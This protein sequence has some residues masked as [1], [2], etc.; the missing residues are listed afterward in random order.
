[1]L[2]LRHTRNSAIVL[3]KH[4][5]ELSIFFE[6][7]RVRLDKSIFGFARPHFNQVIFVHLADVG[8]VELHLFDAHLFSVGLL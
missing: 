7:R 1:M 3:L 2:E 4:V 5:H 6:V 8:R